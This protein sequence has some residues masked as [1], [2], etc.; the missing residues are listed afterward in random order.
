MKE[1]K[2]RSPKWFNQQQ[3]T[4]VGIKRIVVSMKYKMSFINNVLSNM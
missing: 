1:K 2:I 4:L 3:D